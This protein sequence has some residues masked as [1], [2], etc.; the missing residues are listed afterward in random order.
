MKGV[1]FSSE[2]MADFQETTR[3]YISQE[4]EFFITTGVT[5]N[6]T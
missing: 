5:S 1:T 6:P 2:T 4:T 3:S